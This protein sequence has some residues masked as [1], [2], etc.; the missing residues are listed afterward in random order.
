MVIRAGEVSPA[1]QEAIKKCYYIPAD[2]GYVRRQARHE[3]AGQ[4]VR[5]SQQPSN[6]EPAY[7]EVLANNIQESAVFSVV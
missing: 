3:R 6:F 1:L 2:V 7:P 5:G 4:G